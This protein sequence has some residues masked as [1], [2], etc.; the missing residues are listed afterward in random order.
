MAVAASLLNDKQVTVAMQHVLVYKMGIV[1]LGCASEV[2]SGCA[3]G[4][5][6]AL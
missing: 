1:Q 3:G 5:V 4:G 2:G 6:E